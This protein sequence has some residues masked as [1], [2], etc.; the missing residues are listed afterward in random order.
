[1]QINLMAS[2]YMYSVEFASTTSL[3]KMLFGPIDSFPTSEPP[4]AAYRSAAPSRTRTEATG[5]R[6][7]TTRRAIPRVPANRRFGGDDTL[8][9]TRGKR[10]GWWRGVRSAGER[11]PCRGSRGRRRRWF[12]GLFRSRHAGNCRRNPRDIRWALCI[13]RSF[14]RRRS[15]R[16]EKRSSE[17]TCVAD[18]GYIA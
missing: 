2:R 6:P 4:R 10:G 12:R 15:S 9:D 3:F 16:R 5:S 17:Q 18:I 1:M 11:A 8:S 7:D 13:F 14:R